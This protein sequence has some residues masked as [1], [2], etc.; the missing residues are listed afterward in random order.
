MG[1]LFDRLDAVESRS[2]GFIYAGVWPVYLGHCGEIT[3]A[4]SGRHSASHRA[5]GERQFQYLGKECL[6]EG[7]ASGPD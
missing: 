6:G 1:A 4:R 3:L 5:A 2:D 7:A